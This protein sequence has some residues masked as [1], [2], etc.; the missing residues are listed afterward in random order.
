MTTTV[1]NLFNLYFGVFG[2]YI[3][4]SYWSDTPATDDLQDVVD[5]LTGV[6]WGM[7]GWLVQSPDFWDAVIQASLYH[8]YAAGLYVSQASDIQDA[9]A[10]LQR[11]I[12]GYDPHDDV[13][14]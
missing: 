1:R 6:N 5:H 7:R 10:R 8:G 14:A 11:I 13:F 2:N 12:D 9:D 4:P 3:C